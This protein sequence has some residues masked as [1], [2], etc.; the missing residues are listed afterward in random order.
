MLA[1]GFAIL[2]VPLFS[3]LAQGAWAEDFDSYA[4][5]SQLHGSG[6]WKGWN[7]NPAFGALVSDVEARSS[8]HSVAILGSS[9]L[10]HEYSGHT[11]GQWVYT[12]WQYI[13]SSYT[14]QG[15]FILLNTYND[16]GAKS[17]SVQ[18]YFRGSSDI[19]HSDFD[20]SQLALIRGRW[21][22]IRI[23]IDLDADR[24]TFYYDDQVLYQDKVWSTGVSGSGATTIEAVDLYAGGSSTIY[25]DDLSLKSA[26]STSLTSSANP[27]E[28]GDDVTLTASVSSLSTL[29]D[30]PSGFVDFFEG[31]TLLGSAPLNGAGQAT[32]IVSSLSLGAHNLTADYAGDANY[33]PSSGSMVQN[34]VDT[35]PPR[36]SHLDSV[37]D[38]GDGVLS[39]GEGTRALITQLVV[40]FSEDVNDPAGDSDPDDVTNPSNYSLIFD[41]GGAA[42]PVSIDGVAYSALN[43]TA[44]IDLNGGLPLGA[45][46]YRFS[47]HGTPTIQDDQ[48]N[49][50]D[51]NG[52][53]L[54][55][56]DFALDFNIL[57]ERLPQ[58]GFAPNRVTKIAGQIDPVPP[59][60]TGMR[61]LVPSLNKDMQ[62]IG[63]PLAGDGWDVSW[64]GSSAGYLEGTAF[65]TWA[66]NTVLTA[67][68]VLRS[69]LPGP[70]ANLD[71]LE[72]G[73]LIQ[74]EAWGRRYDYLVRE[75]TIVDPDSFEPTVHMDLDWLTLVTCRDYN[76][77]TGTYDHRTVVRAVLVAVEN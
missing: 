18:V 52:D 37:A 11:S 46:S 58:T 41:P 61:L 49:P 72:Y 27:S 5:G 23:E 26:S 50:L 66:G 57:P 39:P 67:H 73:D 36:V 17:W 19:V 20:G 1:A 43:R 13:P 24:Q 30:T 31:A 40:T 74:I 35:V 44:T 69:G 70:F 55:G 71:Q 9:D 14:G 38:T 59:F 60:Q 54:G 10:V 2:A 75:R 51:G 34:V 3:V 48:G 16:G 12:A 8:P 6:G 76:P 62:I 33:A 4:L 47:V 28:F 77:T 7:N 68:S 22:E 29:T 21:V 25:Y 53:G 32:L 64:L 45:G 65:P 15:Y 42:T 56:D 63:V